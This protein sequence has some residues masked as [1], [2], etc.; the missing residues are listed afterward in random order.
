[1]LT[2]ETRN[3]IC[4]ENALKM[5]SKSKNKVEKNQK[6]KFPKLEDIKL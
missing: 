2:E 4:R 6:V 3:K 1:M 5:F